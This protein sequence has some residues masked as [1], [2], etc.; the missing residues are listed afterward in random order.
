MRRKDVVCFSVLSSRHARESV[1][2]LAD[3]FL[4]RN[5]PVCSHF[6]PYS[7][8]KRLTYF[9]DTTIQNGL[10]CV[11]ID[12]TRNNKV[13]AVCLNEDGNDEISPQ[14]AKYFN[15]LIQQNNETDDYKLMYKMVE[16]LRNKSGA[17]EQ[18][19]KTKKTY[20]I[21]LIAID[22]EYENKGIS[23][24]LLK[25]CIDSIAIPMGYEYAFSEATNEYSMKCFLK[26]GFNII[27]TLDYDNWEYPANSNK[28]PK[29]KI[30]NKTGFHTMYLVD[31]HLTKRTVSKL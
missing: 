15:N 3:A 2:I 12:T 1:N 31:K 28:Y 19:I 24:D 26:S 29:R 21:S 11:A 25:Y 17:I 30:A 9:V 7:Y 22:R 8:I 13:V 27:G 20:Y 23:T 6:H 16:D 10:S 14:F 5:E 18:E 4:N